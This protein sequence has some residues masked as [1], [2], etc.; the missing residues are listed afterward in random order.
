MNN[1]TKLIDSLVKDYLKVLERDR[2]ARTLWKRNSA[3]NPVQLRAMRLALTNS[4]QLIQ[5]PPG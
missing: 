1:N 4:F 2:M 5:G 3:L